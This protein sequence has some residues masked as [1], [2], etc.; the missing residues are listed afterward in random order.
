MKENYVSTL[1]VL[2][3]FDNQKEIRQAFI[4]DVIER[5]SNGEISPLKLH[6][7]L[8]VMEEILEGITADNEY[9]KIVL[10]E[11]EKIGRKFISYNAEFQI[12][13]AGVKYD[14]T[15][16]NHSELSEINE[17]I[18]ALKNRKDEIEKFLKTVPAK[19]MDLLNMETGEA[20][21]VYPPVKTSTTVISTK[22]I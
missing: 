19:G 12:K 21:T 3:I 8:K 7:Q 11:A 10:S 22:L 4:E 6:Y 16:C 2:S 15:N 20:Y 18:Q 14:Y 5:V 13:E 1:N 17:K 9:K